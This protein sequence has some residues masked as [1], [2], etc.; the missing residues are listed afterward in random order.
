MLRCADVAHPAL[1]TALPTFRHSSQPVR[2]HWPLFTRRRDILFR[3]EA[4]PCPV[5][6]TYESTYLGSQIAPKDST[7]PA[8]TPA[9]PQ[10]A[11][12]STG[13]RLRPDNK[14]QI[15]R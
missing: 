5:E 3:L 15:A 12:N 2:R 4:I 10:F 14:G 13:S 1:P 8:L 7:A 6:S 11:E 9:M